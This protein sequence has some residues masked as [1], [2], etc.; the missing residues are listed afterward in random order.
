M[1]KKKWALINLGLY[2]ID[3]MISITGMIFA[4]GLQ[5]RNWWILIGL[6]VVMR[7]IFHMAHT[8]ILYDE[9]EERFNLIRERWIIEKTI[10]DEGRRTS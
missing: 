4:F 9:A 5:V 7:W 3:M 1:N 2:I 8:S 10:R 6:C